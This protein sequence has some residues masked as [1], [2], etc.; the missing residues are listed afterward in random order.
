LFGILIRDFEAALTGGDAGN[1]YP[2]FGAAQARP[3]VASVKNILFFRP[4]QG[5]IRFQRLNPSRGQLP[6][7][8]RGLIRRTLAL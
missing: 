3:R 2:L 8:S 4:R 1:G 6:T 5:N 7:V